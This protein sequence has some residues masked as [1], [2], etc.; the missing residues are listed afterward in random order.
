VGI[1]YERKFLV[2][3]QAWREKTSGAKLI[4]QGWLHRDK[5]SEVRVRISDE[6]GSVACKIN[7]D[8]KARRIEL[9]EVID[10]A[11]ARRLL[12]K[13]DHILYKRRWLVLDKGSAWEV[14]EYD[15]ELKGLIVAEI[16]D[17]AGDLEIPGW[18]G[19]EVTGQVGWSNAEL[20]ATGWP[21]L[22]GSGGT[23]HR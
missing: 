21:D 15:G 10:H 6:V 22:R 2:R 8:D 17:P 13:C 20:A 7:L 23:Q 3:G 19:L 5:R 18:V 11:E 1:E 16:E 12:V 9:E 14:D 4:A